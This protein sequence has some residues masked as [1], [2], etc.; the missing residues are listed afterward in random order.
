MKEFIF[1]YKRF[2]IFITA[3]L[4]S[5]TFVSNNNKLS[6]VSA[7]EEQYTVN[8][9]DLN[10]R[11][12]P[13]SDSEILTVL[14]KGVVVTVTDTEGSWSQIILPDTDNLDSLDTSSNTGYVKS[15]YLTKGTSLPTKKKTVSTSKGQKVVTYA[16]KFVGNPYRWG[17][18][19]LTKGADCSGFVKAVYKHFGKN[20][21]HS[22]YSL[23]KVGKKVSSL[24]KAKAG[25][26]ICY[27]G[28]V[29]IYMGN[30]KIVHASNPSTGIKIS[31]NAKYRKIVAIRRIYN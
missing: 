8:T 22:S 25:D 11:I 27:S 13:D 31:S 9:A 21:P 5:I 16:K 17:G 24:K 4:L 10:V 28:H 30:N 3:L 26:I 18:E 6:E 1:S 2:F 29:A 12:E 23:R 20:L 7:A 19:S 15:K 14:D